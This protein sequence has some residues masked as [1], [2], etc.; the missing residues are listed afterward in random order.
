[1]DTRRIDNIIALK[2]PWAPQAPGALAFHLNNLEVAEIS[3]EA[4]QSF[5]NS[6]M[7]SDQEAL[8][9][10][11]SWSQDLG[12][13]SL[14][15]KP[16]RFRSLTL[17]VTQ[18]CNLACHYCAAGGDGTYGDPVK[19]ISIEK[20]IPQL[21]FF[22][23]KLDA[24]ETFS[25]NLLGGEP[26][27]YP[28]GVR[29]IAEYLREETQKRQLQLELSIT[30]N[31]TLITPEIAKMLGT[32]KVSVIIS[33]DGDKKQTDAQRPTKTGESS[34]DLIQQSLQHLQPIRR[35]I[36]R[37]AFHGVFGKNNLDL[38]TAYEVFVA[39]GADQFDFT[40]DHDELSAEVSKAFTKALLEVAATAYQ[41]GGERALRQIGFFDTIFSRLDERA[42]VRHYCGSGQT[43]LM[44]DAKNQVFTCPWDVGKPELQVGAGTELSERR[45]TPYQGD[46]IEKNNDC[47]SC[48]VKNL[49]GGGCMYLHKNRTGNK[50]SVDSVFCDRQRSLISMAISYYYQCR[51]PAES[52][53]L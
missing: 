3:E 41:R 1:M 44:I 23:D 45:L 48:W 37:L 7:K 34:F 18:I 33:M 10:L 30:T 21:R 28:E 35:Q 5:Q 11:K 52:E 50:N 24:E 47:R 9:E 36:P 38:R 26:L 25:V 13:L 39:L 4:W 15:K 19:K 40:F 46:L 8:E 16:S 53:S 14:P 27:L 43:Y 22:L 49:C 17:N 6:A 29:L 12:S 31:G 42:P 32:N 2:K 51:V 20:T